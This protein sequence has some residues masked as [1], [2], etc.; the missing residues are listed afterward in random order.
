MLRNKTIF[1]NIKCLKIRFP[2]SAVLSVFI[3]VLSSNPVTAAPET[4]DKNQK[5]K[6][7]IV[8]Y[9]LNIKE[10]NKKFR[11]YSEIVP[12]SVA[13]NLREY[14]TYDVEH[15]HE[16]QIYNRSISDSKEKLAYLS[17][18]NKIAKGSGADYVITGA[19]EITEN[20]LVID[21]QIYDVMG[22]NIVYIN[23]RSMESGVI[24]KD[25]IDNL[26]LS[27]NESLISSSA[28]NRVKF[29]PS[30]YLSFYRGL[31]RITFGIDA[32]Q[33]HM[34][35]DWSDSLND[36][37]SINSYIQLNLL[38]YFNI[39][40]GVEYMAADNRDIEST[41]NNELMIWEVYLDLMFPVRFS[42]YFGIALNLGGGAAKSKMYEYT[43]STKDGLSLPENTYRTKDMVLQGGISIFFDLGN[44]HLR[45]GS[46]YKRI[47]YDSGD[48]GASFKSD[49]PL[50]MYTVFA[51]AGYNI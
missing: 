1:M 24:L 26:A 39:S 37:D 22:R 29:A 7:K 38:K 27:I 48:F 28:S 51:G 19:C 44:L 3:Y 43:A 6:T 17:R 25:T 35:G 14:G 45:F 33:V 16:V 9:N 46:S 49:D 5:T 42:R 34:V 20:V 8:I 2:F 36:T 10:D 32:G 23:K 21:L 4:T 13:K 40:A 31:S 50:N 15:A 18:L 12:L 41:Y 30:P 11:Y 47:F